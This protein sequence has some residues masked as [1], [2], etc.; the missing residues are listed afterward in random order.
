ML[1]AISFAF[2]LTP[3]PILLTETIANTQPTV[4]I[5]N[6]PPENKLVIYTEG[7]NNFCCTIYTDTTETDLLI[8][9]NNSLWA[10]ALGIWNA[11]INQEPNSI[12]PRY[13]YLLE[14]S[15][16][17]DCTGL[18]KEQC[19]GEAGYISEQILTIAVGSEIISYQEGSS[20][21]WA[22]VGVFVFAIFAVA[23]KLLPTRG[24]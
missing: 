18:T 2:S 17:P 7:E 8:D 1:P 24:F 14:F 4:Q 20:G 13:V 21:M 16:L 23:F 19:K 9:E 15:T 12:L 3:N 5:L 6:F 10:D 11:H 22:L